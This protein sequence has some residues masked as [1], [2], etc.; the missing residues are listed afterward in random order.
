M[1]ADSHRRPPPIAVISPHLDDGVFACGQ[2]LARH[3]GAVVITAFAGRPPSYEPMTEW[4]TSAGFHP[5][6]DVIALRRTEDRSALEILG[7][8]PNW[9]DFCDSQYGHTPSPEMLAD[10]LEATITSLEA[11][12]VYIPLGL[13]HSDHKL[14]HAAMLPVAR[15]HPD[16]AWFA[17]ED[18]MYRCIPGLLQERLDELRCECIDAGRAVRSSDEGHERKR[19]AIEQYRSQLRALK[20]PTRPGYEDALAAERYRR[21]TVVQP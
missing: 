9:L 10:A 17:Y 8:Q 12:A 21:L 7:A 6:H 14:A 11:P 15:R 2:L 20:T 19:R 3:P 4:D 18:A 16:I 13:F 5:G 1:S